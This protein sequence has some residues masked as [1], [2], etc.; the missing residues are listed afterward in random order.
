MA[1]KV[2]LIVDP[3][4]DTAFAVALAFLE[5]KLDVLAL[6]PT[7]GNVSGLQ[8]TINAHTLI[9]QLDPPRYPRLGA[10]PPVTFDVDGTRLHGSDG[11]GNAGF[12]SVSLHNP[13]PSDRL[14]IE[15]VRKH[16]GEVTIV[17]MGPL[18]VMASVV[19]RDPAITSQIDRVICLGGSWRQPGNATAAAEFHIYCDPVSARKVLHSGLPL[20]LLPLDVTRKLIFSPSDLLELPAPESTTSNFLRK[21]I[22]YGIRASSN[23]YGI[24]GFHLKDVL[25]IAAVVLPKSITTV[26]RYVDVETQGELTR[27][28][29]VVDARPNPAGPPNVELA[30]DVDAVAVR[31][32]INQTLR[33]AEF[34]ASDDAL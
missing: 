13:Q 7:P 10:A 32:Y 17:C 33:R 31:D 19:G 34:D 16:P 14:I 1:K 25:G 9:A 28:A 2:I 3:G 18:T 20:T 6:A 22:P 30:T 24:E 11:L 29:T 27:G 4:I 8:A 15:L 23:L 5:P 21:I 26:P 12:P